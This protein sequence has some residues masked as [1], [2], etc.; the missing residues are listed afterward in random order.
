MTEEKFND[1]KDSYVEHLKEIM[2]EEGFLPPLITVIGSEKETKHDSI[3][4]ILVPVEYMASDEKKEEFIEDVLPIASKEVRENFDIDATI[5]SAECWMTLADKNLKP[6]EEKQEAI[7]I[8][9]ESETKNQT[10]IYNIER[11][12]EFVKDKGLV[13]KIELKEFMN[14]YDLPADGRFTGLFKKIKNYV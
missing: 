9:I 11:S 10:L 2:V 1:I 5:W 7:I 3:V 12:L 13:E 6:T 14:D 8:N 4:H